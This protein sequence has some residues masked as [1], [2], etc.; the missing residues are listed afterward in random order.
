MLENWN[1]EEKSRLFWKKNGTWE[2]LKIL[3][4]DF[5]R[6]EYVQVLVAGIPKSRLI[7]INLIT[8]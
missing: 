1:W 6:K 7:L 2:N 4:I 5:Q 8:G 3:G